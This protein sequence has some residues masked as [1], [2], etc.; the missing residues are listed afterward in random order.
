MRRFSAHNLEFKGVV[1]DMWA[2]INRL[3]SRGLVVTIISIRIAL[4]PERFGIRA[5]FVLLAR[6]DIGRFVRR[7]GG[8]RYGV[9]EVK[10][11]F[12]RLV[13][14]TRALAGLN[15]PPALGNPLL[16]AIWC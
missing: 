15:L 11:L 6:P 7:D 10:T 1:A 4:N 3:E 5:E 16:V 14:N 9:K 13:I 12:K 2:D 8:K